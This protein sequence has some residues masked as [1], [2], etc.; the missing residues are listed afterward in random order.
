MKC[1][2]Y[3]DYRT[4]TLLLTLAITYA[5]RLSIACAADSDPND[6]IQRLEQPHTSKKAYHDLLAMGDRVIPLAIAGLES[7]NKDV[8]A[9]LAFLLGDIKT[10]KAIAPL[11]KMAKSKEYSDSSSALNALGKIGGP[12][13]AEAIIAALPGLHP[14][15]QEYFSRVLGAIG[16]NRAIEPLTKLLISRDSENSKQGGDG[17]FK[18]RARQASA[19]ALGKFRDPRA[20]AALVKAIKDDPDWDVYHAAQLSLYRMNGEIY[21]RYDELSATVALAVTKEPEPVNG[22]EEFIRNWHKDHPNYKGSWIGPR[23]EDYASKVDIEHARNAVVERGKTWDPDL[24]AGGVIELL[25][26]YLCNLKLYVGPENAKALLIRIGK[27][28]IPALENG[29][30]RG[31]MI[32]VRN[33]Q[34]CIEAINM[35]SNQPQ[36]TSRPIDNP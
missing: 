22:A 2:L 30:K 4:S 34:Q 1:L 35:P 26:E 27:S 3:L 16:D 15:G 32:L 11:V 21:G 28:A 5:L 8:R 31:D 9:N 12:E 23:L 24:Q 19:E 6:L 14:T 25:M 13:A 29:V 36:Q 17:I 18:V 33:C 7:P 10:D 20:R